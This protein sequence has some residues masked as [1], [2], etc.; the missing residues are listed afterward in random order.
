MAMPRC[1]GKEKTRHLHG[2]VWLL[3]PMSLYLCRDLDTALCLSAPCR[4][5]CAEAHSLHWV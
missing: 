1:M 4:S 2:R 5:T 3:C